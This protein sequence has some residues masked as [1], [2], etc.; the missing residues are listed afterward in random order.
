MFAIGV[1]LIPKA[2]IDED[3]EVEIAIIKTVGQPYDIFG[4]GMS[5]NHPI[6]ICIDP[7]VPVEISGAGLPGLKTVSVFIAFGHFRVVPRLP[8]YCG[9]VAVDNHQLMAAE[10]V[11][12]QFN[13]HSFV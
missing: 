3:T 8:Y 12:S 4:H 10:P 6:V 5:D 11:I 7:V 2:A 1:I 13:S 9:A